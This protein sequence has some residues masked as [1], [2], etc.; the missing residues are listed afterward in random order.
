M[1]TPTLGLRQ[2]PSSEGTG[3]GRAPGAGAHCPTVHVG[4]APGPRPPAAP[5][6]PT[7]PSRGPASAGLGGACT[8][9]HVS[10]TLLPSPDLAKT[11]TPAS[12]DHPTHSFSTHHQEDFSKVGFPPPSSL[13]SLL[14]PPSPSERRLIKLSSPPF[15]RSQYSLS[16]R[17]ELPLLL[18]LPALQLPT[19][20]DSRLPPTQNTNQTRLINI[21]QIQSCLQDPFP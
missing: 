11:L 7:S 15:C 3:G 20:P 13:R 18:F 4:P 21:L 1:K 10:S 8:P 17:I 16:F 6:R 12:D 9:V 5:A 19:N 2:A 14:Q